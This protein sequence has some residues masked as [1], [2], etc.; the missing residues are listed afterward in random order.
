MNTTADI[1]F[2]VDSLDAPGAF[3]FDFVHR[4]DNKETL[5]L[6]PHSVPVYDIRSSFGS[7]GTEADSTSGAPTIEQQGWC[8]R[9]WPYQAD[10]SGTGWEEQYCKDGMLDVM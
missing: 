10:F 4:M 6:Q 5:L 2:V 3:K 9:S 7:V 1:S 8:V